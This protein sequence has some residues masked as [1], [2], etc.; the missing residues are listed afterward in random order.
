MDMLDDKPRRPWTAREL[1]PW[2]AVVMLAGVLYWEHRRATDEERD[3]QKSV[4]KV[5]ADAADFNGRLGEHIGKLDLAIDQAKRD[6]ERK[7]LEM[8]RAHGEGPQKRTR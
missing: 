6:C 3:I 2:A 1:L 4:H 8:E 7:I 5:E